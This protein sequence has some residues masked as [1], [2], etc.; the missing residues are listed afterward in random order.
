MKMNYEE[1]YLSKDKLRKCLESIKNQ[2]YENYEVII[3]NDGT[4]DDSLKI[5][6]E[7]GYQNN[8]KPEANISFNIYFS[9]IGFFILNIR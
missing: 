8:F 3:V 9:C 5:I 1:Y 6:K 4:T 7:Y 2:T